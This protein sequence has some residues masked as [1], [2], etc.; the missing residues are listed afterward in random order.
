M[1][2]TLKKP[3][4]P[5]SLEEVHAHCASLNY[6]NGIFTRHQRWARRFI[7]QRMNGTRDTYDT[8]LYCNT[9]IIRSF[10]LQ[11]SFQ[12]YENILAATLWT[13]SILKL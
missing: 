5:R 13:H 1:K 12:P 3:E 10:L 7:E 4:V 6:F 9:I 2:E 8:Y 11:T